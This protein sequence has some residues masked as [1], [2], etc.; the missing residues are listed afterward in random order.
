MNI[1]NKIIV[2]FSL[3]TLV[4]CGI[5]F[6]LIYF[7]YYENR[8]EEFQMRQKKK[9]ITTLNFLSQIRETD[10]KLVENIDLLTVHDLYDEKL[11]LFNSSKELIYSSLDDIPVHF[12]LE[13]LSRLTPENKWVETKDGLY[14]VIGTYVESNGKTF[15]GISKAYD[16]FGYAKLRYL[17]YILAASFISISIIVIIISFYLSKKITAPLSTVTKKVIAYNFEEDYK[18]IEVSGSKDEV[19]L[20]ALQFN[21]LMKRMNEAFAFQKHAVHHISHEL[22]TPISILVSNF[23]KI[24]RETDPGKI[25]TLI[26]YQKED[27]RNLSEIINALLEIARTETGNVLKQDKFRIDELIFD[28]AEELKNI[29]PD[30]QFVIT[31]GAQTKDEDQLTVTANARLIKSALMNLMQNCILYS[32]DNKAGITIAAGSRPGEIIFENNGNPISENETQYLFQHF[33]RGENSQGKRGFGLGLVLV[34]RIISL[35]G[36]T[37]SYHSENKESNTFIV[38][39]PF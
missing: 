4:I 2:Y 13:I 21:K 14:D 35:H 10:N 32:N 6:A 34:H 23:E 24:E 17:E 11:L 15:Y 19:T 38:R 18:P 36:G 27:T 26:K 30:F 28:V 12:S 37:I 31:Y 8:E 25:K 22:K 20:L 33:F 3:A 1:R 7:L 16:T 39:L 9:I 5:T 29:Y